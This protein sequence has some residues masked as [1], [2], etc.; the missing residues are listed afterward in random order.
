MHVREVAGCFQLV[1]LW[2]ME[3]ILIEPNWNVNLGAQKRIPNLMN[4]MPAIL[5]AR[6]SCHLLN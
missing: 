4:S 1:S 5:A 6:I 3:L 2:M